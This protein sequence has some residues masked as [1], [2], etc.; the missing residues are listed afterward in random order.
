MY[1]ID[2]LGI[3]YFG[4]WGV[5]LPNF[6]M[7]ASNHIVAAIQGAGDTITS[8]WDSEQTELIYLSDLSYQRKQ[9]SFAVSQL[10]S[11]VWLAGLETRDILGYFA[12]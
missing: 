3:S 7:A 5:G 8:A 4:L 9:A 10:S 2:K 11:A 1:Y 12:I 6:V